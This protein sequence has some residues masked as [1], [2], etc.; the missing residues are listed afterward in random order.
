MYG[1]PGAHKVRPGL[2]VGRVSETRFEDPMQ[3]ILPSAES[4]ATHLDSHSE[5]RM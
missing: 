4:K 3:V 2:Y 1:T 5:I